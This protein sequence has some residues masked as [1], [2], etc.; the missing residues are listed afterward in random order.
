[1]VDDARRLG[2]D[3]EA[4]EAAIRSIVEE[5]AFNVSVFLE[6]SINEITGINAGLNAMPDDA[7]LKAKLIVAEDRVLAPALAE[8]TMEE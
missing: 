7:E 2:F 1:M 4:R 3:V 5:R 8:Q 6:L